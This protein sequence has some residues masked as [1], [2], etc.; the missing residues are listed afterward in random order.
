[1]DR[2]AGAGIDDEVAVPDADLAVALEVQPVTW[3]PS[4]EI[5]GQTLGGLLQR[6][7][8]A[9]ANRAAPA[10]TSSSQ[11]VAPFNPA[12]SGGL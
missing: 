7:V 5:Q 4:M 10:G 6:V 3:A 1:V 11:R 2:P 8:G 9:G 12:L